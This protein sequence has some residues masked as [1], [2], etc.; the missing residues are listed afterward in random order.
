MQS[1][2][3]KRRGPKPVSEILAELFASKGLARLGAARALEDAWNG[4]VGTPRCRQTKLG[5]V[6][7]GI[8]NVTVANSALLEELA[9]FEKPTLL[10]ALR[11]N[12]PDVSVLD[13]RFRVGPVFVP[14][15]EPSKAEPP[16]RRPSSFGGNRNRDGKRSEEGS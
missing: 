3:P 10:K 4:A 16:P 8:L 12:V 6:R 9:A 11:E 15:P 1:P 7:R 13:I 2:G 14:P 5:E